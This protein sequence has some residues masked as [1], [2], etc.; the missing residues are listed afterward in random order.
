[1]SET[2]ASPTPEGNPV[3]ALKVVRP[4]GIEE[5]LSDLTGVPLAKA[6]ELLVQEAGYIRHEGRMSLQG[7]Y[8]LYIQDLRTRLQQ[9][10]HHCCFDPCAALLRTADIMYMEVTPEGV[11][12]LGEQEDGEYF[13]TLQRVK[14]RTLGELQ[15]PDWGMID[16]LEEIELID[17]VRIVAK[18]NKCGLLHAL[19]ILT[20]SHRGRHTTQDWM[21]SLIPALGHEEACDVVRELMQLQ[22]A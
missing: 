8:V 1:M 12:M 10:H 11:F 2:P 6:R 4:D 14:I 15:K 19:E 9:D 20:V 18:R 17:M 16:P 21:T 7:G 13:K 3:F 5:N 22:D